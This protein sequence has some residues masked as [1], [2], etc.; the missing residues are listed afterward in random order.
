MDVVFQERDGVVIGIGPLGRRWQV[1][2]VVA[3][4]RLEFRDAGD[5]GMTYAGTHQSLE[6][7]IAAARS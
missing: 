7:A 2:R 4:W 5:P 3:G 1:K 6:A